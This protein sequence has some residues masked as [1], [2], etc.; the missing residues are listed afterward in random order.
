[1]TGLNA[2]FLPNRHARFDACETRAT[3]FPETNSNSVL[4]PLRSM[5][6]STLARGSRA[7]PIVECNQHCLVGV[8]GFARRR[9]LPHSRK[10]L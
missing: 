4:P 6:P 7:G 5:I 3:A 9:C 8:G 1:M 2:G 10:M